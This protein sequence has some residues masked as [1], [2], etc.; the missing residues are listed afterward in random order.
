MATIIDQLKV[1]LGLDASDYEKAQK[2][3]DESFKRSKEK[4]DK[5]ANDIKD[6]GKK[7]AEF[8]T[9]LEKSAI[10]FFALFTAGRGMADFT[11]FVVHGGAQLARMSQNLGESTDKLSRW[12][13]AVKVAGGTQEGF[14]NTLKHF[15]TE[16]TQFALTGQSG[17]IPL[18]NM[19]GVSWSDAG[20][21]QKSTIQFL[22]DIGDKL[23]AMPRDKAYFLSQQLGIDE[24]SFNLLMM[25]RK[26]VEKLVAA[27]KAFTDKDAKAALQAEQKWQQAKNN[28]EGL[29]RGI[30][31]KLLPSIEKLMTKF[32]EFAEFIVPLIIQGID[33]FEELDKATGGVLSTVTMLYAGIRL[34]FGVNILTGLA[35]LTAKLLGVGKAAE[36]AAG[37]G[38]AST[39]LAAMLP[40][41]TGI[42]ATLYS[43]SLNVGEQDIINKQMGG[44][45]TTT[46]TKG[47]SIAERLNNPGDI[48]FAGQND[49]IKDQGS[50]FAVFKSATA[51]FA[52]MAR[53]LAKYQSRGINT[54]R[55]ITSKWSPASENNVSQNISNLV[56]LTGFGADQQLNLSD[57]E[58][59]KKVIFGISKNEAANNPA[60]TN[61]NIMAGI[62]SARGGNMNVGSVVINTQ[63]TD[64]RGIARDFVGQL[65]VMQ[66]EGG[67]R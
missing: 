14:L 26:E 27:Q 45:A 37:V 18:M 8:F 44:N 6:S 59:L 57:A 55:K 51:G 13:G 25:G 5:T 35:S 32:A 2:R 65:R 15:Q 42:V 30:V 67:P 41:L 21:K 9:Q 16:R 63:A 62:Q 36:T 46:E 7:G 40:W 28:I 3:V 24:G 17:M 34:L 20:G 19:L 29:T 58:T 31:I 48:V 12:A 4:A 10:K 1:V 52:A 54:L 23:R 49:A 53:Q 61:A 47:K 64:A 38:G 33:K 66:A 11:A 60:I 22:Q 56:G 43:P 50:K 39:G